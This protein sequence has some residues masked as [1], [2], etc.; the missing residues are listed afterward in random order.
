MANDLLGNCWRMRRIDFGLMIANLIGNPLRELSWGPYI[1]M[2][3]ALFLGYVGFWVGIGKMMKSAII[4]INQSSKKKKS[5]EK[6]RGW[7]PSHSRYQC[8]H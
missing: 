6:R 7:F 1:T 4:L 8:N 5:I 3:L 2:A